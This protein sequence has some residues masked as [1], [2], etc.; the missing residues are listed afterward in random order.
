MTTRDLGWALFPQDARLLPWVAAAL[1]AARH[2]VADP[3]QRAQWL[4]C[5]GTWFVG[6]DALPTALDGAILGIA[7]D[8]AVIDALAPLPGLHRAQLSVVYPGY[9]RPRAGEGAKAFA[10]RQRRDAAHVDGILPV[11]PQRR[12][13]VKEPHAFILG[14]PLTDCA[15]E[16]SPLAVWEGS[17]RVIGTALCDALRPYP[18]ETWAEVDITEAYQAARKT[19]F[20]TLPRVTLAA[21]PGE[22]LLMHPLTLH[23]IAPW[24]DGATA[25]PE[26][27]MIAYFRPPMA[28][29]I[30]A[31]LRCPWPL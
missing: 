16:A 2:V 25:P 10:Y 23:G 31:W 28:G 27:R 30:S 1:E 3:V 15:P 21:R 29:G 17:H 24:A 19:C 13:H 11:G 22:A 4:Q 8:G 26:G 12:R 14:L 18:V 9:P 7:L 5:D 20:E 6:V